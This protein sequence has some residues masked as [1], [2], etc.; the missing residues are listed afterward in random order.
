MNSTESKLL[1]LVNEN[2]SYTAECGGGNGKNGGSIRYGVREFQAAYKLIALGL[3]AEG[4]KQTDVTFMGNGNC[5]RTSI[6]VIKKVS[7]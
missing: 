4:E 7:Q 6:L 2:G 1:K 3:V 5:V